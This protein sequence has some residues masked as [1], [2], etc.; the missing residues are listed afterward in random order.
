MS[1]PHHAPI[2]SAA[3]SRGPRSACA[4]AEISSPTFRA[5]HDGGAGISGQQLARAH[6]RL[7]WTFAVSL[8]R[9]TGGIEDA[10]GRSIVAIRRSAQRRDS[11]SFMNSSYARRVSVICLNPTNLRLCVSRVRLPVVGSRIDRAR[12]RLTV[13]LIWNRMVSETVCRCKVRQRS[14][15]STSMAASTCPG[16]FLSRVWSTSPAVEGRFVLEVTLKILRCVEKAY[17]C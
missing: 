15:R 10:V 13:P 2:M 6:S 11:V 4:G 9:A 1:A 17:E 3:A 5:A 7:L 8:C 12:Q 14:K 16:S